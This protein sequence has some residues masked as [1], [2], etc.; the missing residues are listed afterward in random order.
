MNMYTREV[1]PAQF[2]NVKAAVAL[3]LVTKEQA[4][5]ARPQRERQAA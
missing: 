1:A 5:A 3:K 2:V 4:E